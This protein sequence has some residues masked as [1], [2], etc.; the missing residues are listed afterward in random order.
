MF[1][2]NDKKEKDNK[3]KK[4]EDRFAVPKEYTINNGFGDVKHVK[5]MPNGHVTIKSGR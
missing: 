3:D 1:W 5:I 2:E 4:E